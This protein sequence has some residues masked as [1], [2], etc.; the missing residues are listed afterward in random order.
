MRRVAAL[1]GWLV[2]VV[3]VL[4]AGAVPSGASTVPGPSPSPYAVL[5]A[6]APPAPH[7]YRCMLEVR[8]RAGVRDGTEVPALAPMVTLPASVLTPADI[9]KAY[10]F[11]R[12][13]VAT[14]AGTTIALVDAYDD[15]TLTRDL[16]TFSDQF[17]LP[18]CTI[19][20]GCLS[21]VDQSGGTAM[22]A[23][24]TQGTATSQGWLGETSLDVEWAHAMAPKAHL[25]VVEASSAGTT[26]FSAVGYA[27][28]HASYVSMSWGGTETPAETSV[29][30]AVF[31]P[32]TGSVSFFAS[33]GDTASQVSY[34]AASPDVVSVGGTTLT[35][36][37]TG[38]FASESAWSTGGGGCSAYERA[39]AAQAAYPTYDQ[40]AASCAGMRA[41]PD[42]AAD[43]NPATGV[44]V[45]DSTT[46]W[47]QVGGTS[48]SA[49][50]WA[51]HAADAGIHVDA[52]VVYGH[53]IPFYDVTTGSNGHQ[54]V[55]GY[56]LCDGLGSWN[57]TVGTANTRVPGAPGA[58]SAVAG[59]GQAT[60]SWQAPTTGGSPITRYTVTSTPAGGSCM[61]SGALDC[62][63]GGLANGTTYTFSVTAHNAV[64]TGP[65]STPS[66]PVTPATV[67]RTG[68]GGDATGSTGPAPYAPA[69][70]A[71]TST[72]MSA[73]ST[74][75][76]GTASVTDASAGVRANASGA[77]AITVARYA[78]DP[79][80]VAPGSPTGTYV[81]VGV[82][83]GS[84]F[85]SLV[86]RVCGGAATSGLSWWNGTVWLPFGDE[87][88]GSGGCVSATVTGTTTP[89]LAQLRG[90]PVATVARHVEA[91]RIAGYTADATAV[92][93]LETEF[94]ATGATRSCVG[95]MPNS[96][97]TRPVV[98]AT[99][100]TFP[101]ALAAS[102]L[103]G[104]LDTGV[105]LTPTG[106]LAPV[107]AAALKAEGVTRVF[108]VGGPLAVSDTVT[109]LLSATPA[110]GCGGTAALGT[111]ITVTRI[112]GATEYD[113]A[114]MIARA[115]SSADV[116]TGAFPGAYAGTDSVGGSGSYNDTAGA[117]TP[118]P[119][120]SAPLRTAVL[121]TGS[122]YQDAMSASAMAYAMG[123]PVLLSA[124]GSLSPAAQ[125]AIT[126]LTIRQ[127][128]VMGGP[129][130]VSDGV[131]RTLASLGVS[132][133]RVAGTDAT[134][135]AVELA[136]FEVAPTSDGLGWSGRASIA[137]TRG[138]FFTDGLAGSVVT[139]TTRMPLVLTESPT[140]PGPYLTSF[141]RASGQSGSGIAG[142]AT[143]KVLSLV[144]LGGPLAVATSLVASLESD[145]A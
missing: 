68:T 91:A 66:A 15:T 78:A 13:D 8:R 18:P 114:A 120:T 90:T 88:A 125:A 40:P 61:T 93:E 24:A 30:A 83:A 42:V 6:C 60:V 62:S 139:G 58:P 47:M 101:D 95:G 118:A 85:T 107:T 64:G 80:A 138:D 36:A 89:R 57:A 84:T 76:T 16:A 136:R 131:V 127:V 141:L 1:V 39:T 113:T 86:L 27:A 14:G 35:L 33:A 37:P 55:A 81:D 29:D 7:H 71:G 77:G 5:R 132:V 142:L 110:Y 140:A 92:K 25:L 4:A 45:Y 143:S 100:R 133:L 32:H 12:S 126:A 41:T 124:T 115:V 105:L 121:A 137:V 70:P 103:A 122:S 135:T 82:A 72:A 106:S 9:M 56:N 52:S 67:S 98:V 123:F 3:A 34:P 108:V 10:G 38:S 144:T 54:C 21:Q 130:A 97:R 19:A 145:L 129:L 63:V 20:N 75:P 112:G 94:P 104:A 48:L 65:A 74:T 69:A 109:T 116:G 99:T 79:V 117:G 11:A 2:V 128:V 73:T 119:A 43:A 49:P 53:S 50:L 96:A 26:L 59:D 134:D 17:G 46:G 51:G 23:P 44:A 111:D 102:Y 22:P 87:Q 31:A 28:S